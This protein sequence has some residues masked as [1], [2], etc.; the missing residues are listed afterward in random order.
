MFRTVQ[1][2]SGPG[3]DDAAP[4][5]DDLGQWILTL[6]ADPGPLDRGAAAGP[7]GVQAL[8]VERAFG[9]ALFE[10]GEGFGGGG[11]GAY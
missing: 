11:R 7:S 10:D 1:N 4:K 8:E 2:G 6:P 9:A 5:G 3:G